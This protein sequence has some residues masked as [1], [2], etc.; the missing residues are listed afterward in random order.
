MNSQIKEV[1]FDIYCEKCKDKRTKEFKDPCNQCLE[2][3]MRIGSEVPV[4]FKAREKK[5]IKKK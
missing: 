1:R 5:G 3:A 2:T 4:H